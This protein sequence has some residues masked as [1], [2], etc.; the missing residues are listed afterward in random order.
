MSDI[1]TSARHSIIAISLAG[2]SLSRKSSCANAAP[3]ISGISNRSIQATR[4]PV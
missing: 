3:A 2:A 1:T 4:A